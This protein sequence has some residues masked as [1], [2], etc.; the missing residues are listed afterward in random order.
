MYINS[1]GYF[2]NSINIATIIISILEI[3]KLRHRGAK[4]LA[5][6][7]GWQVAKAEFEPR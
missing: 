7:M 5:E 1:F 3:K 4:W 2:N 6:V